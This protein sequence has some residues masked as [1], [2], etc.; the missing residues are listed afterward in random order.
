MTERLVIASPVGPLTI[1]TAG[2]VLVGIHFGALEPATGGG[3]L[4]RAA[5]RQL[6]EYF[7]GRRTAF[8]LPLEPQGTPFRRRVWAA[9]RRV[10]YGQTRSYGEVA[11]EI[12]SAPRA[13]G[14]ACGANPLPIVVPC[15]RIVGAR[16]WI[17]GFSGGQGCATKRYLLDAEAARLRR[18]A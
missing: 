10:P 3:A 5:A 8:D 15:H 13:V 1:E 2:G 16:G 4:G 17:G 6:R 11:V 9:M 12:G 14:G 7:D 18:P